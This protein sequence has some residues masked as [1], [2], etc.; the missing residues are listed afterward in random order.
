MWL[1]YCIG[2]GLI[3]AEITLVPGVGIIGV[4]GFLC[5]LASAIWMTQVYSLA[6]GSL[7]FLAGL[8]GAAIVFFGFLRSPA[9][10]RFVLSRTIQKPKGYEEWLKMGSRGLTSTP[11]Y[12]SGK[13]LFVVDGSE[14]LLDV[15]SGGEFIEQGKEI[16]VQAI[17]GTRIFVSAIS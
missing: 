6:T 1:L 9:S 10:K 5:L 8:I 13:A 4:A 7:L 2:L 15:S 17:E 16:Q 12:P 3:I 11:L 14:T